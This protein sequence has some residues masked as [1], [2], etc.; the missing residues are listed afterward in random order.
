MPHDYSRIYQV[1]HFGTFVRRNTQAADA[2][3]LVNCAVAG[4]LVT[5]E[6][7]NF[8]LRLATMMQPTR[9]LVVASLL[10][11]E[12]K[13]SV[14]HFDIMRAAGFNDPLPS[15][16]ELVFAFGARRMVAAP[17]FSQHVTGCDKCKYE[18]FLPVEGVT[19]ASFYGPLTYTP[20]TVL[21][22]KRG[23]G[24]ALGPLVASGTLRTVNADLLIIKKIILTAHPTKVGEGGRS[25]KCVRVC[26]C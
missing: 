18:R 14:L 8:P 7:V 15:K 19:T 4:Q 12:H 20:C 24:G 1:P 5:L 10:K 22:F 9:P 16:E 3:P 23:D 17:L 11:Y 13:T 25:A 21:V 6:I 26:V 2:A